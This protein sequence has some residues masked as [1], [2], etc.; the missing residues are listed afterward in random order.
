MTELTPTDDNLPGV[1]PFS[2]NRQHLSYDG[3]LEVRGEIIRAV[4][5][6]EVVHSHEH[7]QI[8]SS[9]SSLTGPI[10]LCLDSFVF[11]FVFFMFI[12]SCT[13]HMCCIIVTWWP[14]GPGE[15]ES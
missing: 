4:L 5:Y 1:H 6:T 2:S 8:S 9:Y 10:S 13:L 14:G 15:I 3:C 12:L 7:T 11:M